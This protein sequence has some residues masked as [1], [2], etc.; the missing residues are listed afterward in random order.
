MTRLTRLAHDAVRATLAPGA[1][2]VDATAGN[3]HDTLFLAE[4]VGP[5]GREPSRSSRTASRAAA[6]TGVNSSWRL[7]R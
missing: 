5:G 1:F 2:A 6:D 4:A 7:G 3:G